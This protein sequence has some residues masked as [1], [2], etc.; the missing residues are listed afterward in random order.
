MSADLENLYVCTGRNMDPVVSMSLASPPPQTSVDPEQ[1]EEAVVQ[2]AE[3]DGESS[4]SVT[5]R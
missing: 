4:G 5:S 2:V 1:L 3:E